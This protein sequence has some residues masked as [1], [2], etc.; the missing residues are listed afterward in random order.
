VPGVYK[1]EKNWKKKLT[2]EQRGLLTSGNL[3]DQLAGGTAPGMP[4]AYH[5]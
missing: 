2:K 4:K 3:P 1:Y 5:K